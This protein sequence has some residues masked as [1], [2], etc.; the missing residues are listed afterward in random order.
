MRILRLLPVAL[1]A[2]MAFGCTDDDDGN[3]VVVPRR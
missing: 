2:M 1:L 3:V